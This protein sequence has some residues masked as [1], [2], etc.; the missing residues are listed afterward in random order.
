MDKFEP[1]LWLTRA[2][3]GLKAQPW[4]RAAAQ[5][6]GPPT[7]WVAPVLNS[8]SKLVLFVGSVHCRLVFFWRCSKAC[9]SNL[10]PPFF[11][12]VVFIR[13]KMLRLVSRS[14]RRAL[15][16]AKGTTSP[17]FDVKADT[18]GMKYME[19]N[20]SGVAALRLPQINKGVVYLFEQ[21]SMFC[22][23]L[24]FYALP[25]LASF[26]FRVFFALRVRGSITKRNKGW[27]GDLS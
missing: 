16:R 24:C 22:P 10:V 13:L 12:V 20:V 21:E 18:R 26:F 23:L 27:K 9:R 1:P 6:F 2:M 19:V 4:F 8:E 11:A 5:P 15:V 14:S 3:P 25:F 17:Y 7:G